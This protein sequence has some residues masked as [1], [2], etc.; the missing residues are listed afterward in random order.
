VNTPQPT[1]PIAQ[2]SKEFVEHLRLVHF[3]LLL[4]STA[5]LYLT[6]ASWNDANSLRAALEQF[7]ATFEQLADPSAKHHKERAAATF[8]F[9]L[10]TAAVSFNTSVPTVLTFQANV[11]NESDLLLSASTT[12]PLFAFKDQDLDQL[13]LAIEG[14]TWKI[15][16][17]SGLSALDSKTWKTPIK[18]KGSRPTLKVSV[19]KDASSTASNAWAL[20]QV[21]SLTYVLPT[22]PHIRAY[23]QKDEEMRGRGLLLVTNLAARVSENWFGKTFPSLEKHWPEISGNTFAEAWRLAVADRTKELRGRSLNLLGLEINAEHVGWI[24]P[25][26]IFSLLIYLQIY[27]NHLA[28]VKLFTCSPPYPWVG[29]IPMPSATIVSVLSIMIVPAAAVYL[30][31]WH[32]IGSALLAIGGAAISILVACGIL[33]GT[34]ALSRRLA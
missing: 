12:P 13:R 32:L 21:Y 34:F 7:R 27:V 14:A 30:A 4:I 3:S 29:I 9:A 19:E 24:G 31:F 16:A 33:K 23:Y 22:D 25:L 18:L 1:A 15:R 2:D 6:L 20:L 17:F 10:K 26:L 8:G 11:T 28:T 5:L